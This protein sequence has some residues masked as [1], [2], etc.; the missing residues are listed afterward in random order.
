LGDALEKR[1]WRN[2]PM[3][4]DVPATCQVFGSLVMNAGIEGI[5][6]DSS[7][8]GRECIAIFPQ[9]FLTPRPSSNWMTPFRQRWFKHVP[10]RAISEILFELRRLRTAG[11]LVQAGADP[12]SVQGQMR[13]TRI[14]TTMDIYAQIVPVAQRRAVEK[15]SEF[16]DESVPKSV[17]LLSQKTGA[18]TDSKHGKADWIQ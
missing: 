17:P 4:Y 11:R 18:E 5:R 16:V 3:I 1:D 15:L 9:N 7:I 6:Y 13:H 14:S 12:K 8:T 2:W 10:I